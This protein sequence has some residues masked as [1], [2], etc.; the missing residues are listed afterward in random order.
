MRVTRNSI[1][2]DLRRALRAAKNPEPALAAGAQVVVEHAKRA[3]RESQ[4]RPTAWQ[5]LAAKT[6]AEKQRSRKSNAM[7]IREGRLIRTPRL[8]T[9]EKRRVI[10]GSD[11]FYAR[12]HQIG[13]KKIPARPFWPFHANGQMTDRTQTLVRSVIRRKLGV[14]K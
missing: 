6:L 9:R 8:V 12:F 4:L 10:V 1:G 7:L 5:A 13:T 14:T 2:D 11:L 3:F